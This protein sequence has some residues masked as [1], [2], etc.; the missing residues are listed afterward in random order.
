MSALVEG[1][2]HTDANFIDVLD[3]EDGPVG[4]ECHS[5]PMLGIERESYLFS[6]AVS[7]RSRTFDSCVWNPKPMQ[8]GCEQGS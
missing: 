5:F 4:F 2:S 7:V 3:N 1:G 6:E 8:A